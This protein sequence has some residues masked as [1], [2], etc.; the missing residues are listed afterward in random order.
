[1]ICI[2][3]GNG[4]SSSGMCESWSS[5]WFDGWSSGSAVL[6]GCYMAVE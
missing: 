4:G 1:M 6:S 2:D 5:D 3:E